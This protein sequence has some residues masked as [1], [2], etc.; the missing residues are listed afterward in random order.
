[1]P[2]GFCPVEVGDVPTGRS[3]ASSTSLCEVQTALITVHTWKASS[4]PDAFPAA[5]TY[6]NTPPLFC[7]ATFV[8]TASTDDGLIVGVAY[9]EPTFS[10]T[11]PSE[12]M[13]YTLN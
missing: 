1:M 6:T 11:M 13:A 10:L 3:F 12:P 2:T 5:P 8:L 4:A 7:G 9:G